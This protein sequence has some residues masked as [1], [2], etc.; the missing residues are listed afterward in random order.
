MTTGHRS[1]RV[2]DVRARRCS[3]YQLERT[4]HNHRLRRL[5]G[6]HRC[7]SASGG[8]DRPHGR[9]R[10]AAG[11]GAHPR[12][13]VMCGDMGPGRRP[14]PQPPR[15]RGAP[16]GAQ[17][18]RCRRLPC[19]YDGATRRHRS[20]S[21]RPTLH[22]TWVRVGVAAVHLSV[23]LP[24]SPMRVRRGHTPAS[25]GERSA[26]SKAHFTHRSVHAGESRRPRVS[27]REYMN[28]SLRCVAAQ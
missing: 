14:Q 18:C 10:T 21:A 5:S 23:S 19:E 22:S 15:A 28:V 27:S 1:E 20:G 8:S 16:P 7:N 26:R 2:P 3:A 11:R 13:V 24:A 4:K 17:T 9:V 6:S 12:P 25:L